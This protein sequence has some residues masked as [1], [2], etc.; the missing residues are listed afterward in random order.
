MQRAAAERRIGRCEWHDLH[1]LQRAL[2]GPVPTI[3]C[4]RDSI[5]YS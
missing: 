1:R 2:S 4:L 3:G 5:V